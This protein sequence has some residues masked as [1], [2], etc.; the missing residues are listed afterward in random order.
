MFNRLK[1][2]QQNLKTNDFRPFGNQTFQRDFKF[3]K[4]LWKTHSK[5]ASRTRYL[6]ILT[7]GTEYPVFMYNEEKLKLQLR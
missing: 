2:K 5:M 7:Y 1:E 6:N 3:F 4:S